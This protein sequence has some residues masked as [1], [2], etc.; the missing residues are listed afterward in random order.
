MILLPMLMEGPAQCFFGTA[1]Y[2]AVVCSL[3]GVLGGWRSAVGS[4]FVSWCSVHSPW[5]LL[6]IIVNTGNGGG[7]TKVRRWCHLH[8]PWN[9]EVVLVLAPIRFVLSSSCGD[10][11]FASSLCAAECQL[12]GW[13]FTAS[14]IGW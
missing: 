10:E 1:V 8:H 11:F 5:A 3:A 9:L 12:S 2:S 14:L 7:T 13:R 4:V 6:H